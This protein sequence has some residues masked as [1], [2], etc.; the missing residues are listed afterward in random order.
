[1]TFVASMRQLEERHVA[2]K[3][4]LMVWSNKMDLLAFSNTKGEVALHRLNWQRVWLLTPP[5]ENAHVD[6]LMWRP[7]G[8][9]IAIAYSTSL[10][11]N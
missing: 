6:A 5:V 1:M 4:E 10:T 11:G 7:D 2:T 9:V 3:I 8:K